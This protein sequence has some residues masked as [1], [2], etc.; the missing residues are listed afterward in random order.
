MSDNTLDKNYQPNAIEQAIYETWE[1][2]PPTIWQAI[3]ARKVGQ[4]V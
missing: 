4:Y 1:E 2:K 3:F